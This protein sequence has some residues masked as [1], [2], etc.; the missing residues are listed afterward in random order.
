MTNLRSRG[1]DGAE[2]EVCSSLVLEEVPSTLPGR[3]RQLRHSV[4]RK[5]GRTCGMLLLGSAG[6]G[7][8]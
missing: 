7:W 1:H 2:R 6:G 3:T 8:C 4:G 5:Y